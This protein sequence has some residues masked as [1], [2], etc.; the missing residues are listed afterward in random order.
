[1]FARTAV[2]TVLALA[3]L[4]AANPLVARHTPES[5]TAVASAS[6]RKCTVKSGECCPAD[7]ACVVPADGTEVCLQNAA[8]SECPASYA[9]GTSGVCTLQ[10]NASGACPRC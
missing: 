10:A 6:T 1:M 9:K 2:A 4:A 5:C 7:W 3:A 8:S